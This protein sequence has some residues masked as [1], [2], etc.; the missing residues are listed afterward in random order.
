MQ[1]KELESTVYMLLRSGRL[2][3]AVILVSQ[4][5]SSFVGADRYDYLALKA[6]VKILASPFNVPACADLVDEVLAAPEASLLT[7]LK[8]SFLGAHIA[9]ELKDAGRWRVY[10]AQM[11][12]YLPADERFRGRA[13]RGEGLFQEAHGTAGAAIACYEAAMAWHLENVGPHDERDRLCY[14]GLI[15]S[16]LARVHFCEGDVAAVQAVADMA[17]VSIPEDSSQRVYV[18]MSDM[19]L[20]LLTNNLVGAAAALNE[21]R[22]ILAKYP[23]DY[24]ARQLDELEV[25]LSHRQGFVDQAQDV[26]EGLAKKGCTTRNLAALRSSQALAAQ[27][28]DSEGVRRG[29][30]GEAGSGTCDSDVWAASGL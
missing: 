23:D 9:D 27:L 6:N 7:K 12:A 20:G 8:A 19:R 26:L 1:Y 4:H 10:L 3:Q 24:A 5:M 15:C 2:A 25:T 29:V 22:D 30:Q 21:A 14:L 13:L 11:T 17:R 16:D 18:P 28:G